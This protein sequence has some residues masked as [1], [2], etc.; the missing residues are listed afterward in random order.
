MLSLGG[1]ILFPSQLRNWLYNLPAPLVLRNI[2]ELVVRTI[3]NFSRNDGLHM[4]AGMAF[5][6]LLSMFPLALGAVAIAGFFIGSEEAQQGLFD[7]LEREVPGASGIIQDNIRD[8]VR[9]RSAL[10]LISGVF[11]FVAGRAVFTALRRVVN[12]AWGVPTQRHFLLQQLREGTMA[13]V[14]ALVLIFSV[15]LSTFGQFIAQGPGLLGVHFEFVL[16][17]WA[18]LFTLVPLVLNTAVFVLIFRFVPATGVRWSYVTPIAVLTAVV[19]EVAQT[20][21]VW[22]LDNFASFDRIYGGISTVVVL[23]LWIYVMSLILII[24]VETA[25]EYSRSIE[26]G[27]FRWRGSW[28]FVKGGLGPRDRGQ[29]EEEAPPTGT[30]GLRAAL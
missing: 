16:W 15:L 17:T 29:R 26:R 7:F 14:A 6:A 18:T 30:S 24:G 22:F 21:F 27:S 12:R 28:R 1:R 11:F 9:S 4:A 23:L 13:L 8:V 19:F 3:L 25:S 2:G 20:I 10:G 5:Y